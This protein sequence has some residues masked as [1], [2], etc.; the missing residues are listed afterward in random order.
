[1][2][3]TCVSQFQ[4]DRWTDGQMDGWGDSY[5]DTDMDNIQINNI[6]YVPQEKHQYIKKC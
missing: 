3:A 6:G 4:T 2:I 5:T 1:M